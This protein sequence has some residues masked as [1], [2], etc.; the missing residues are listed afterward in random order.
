MKVWNTRVHGESPGH[1]A[2]LETTMKQISRLGVV[3]PVLVLLWVGSCSGARLDSVSE[4]LQAPYSP[5]GDALQQTDLAG[6][7]ETRYGERGVDRLIFRVDGTFKQVYQDHQVQDYVYETPW[8]E[9]W[10]ERLHDGGL[11]I[12]LQGARYY[13]AGVDT[14]ELGGMLHACADDQED[15]RGQPGCPPFAFYDPIEDDFVYMVGELV[16]SVRGDSSGKLLLH[17]MWTHAD[18]GFAMFGCER[19]QFRRLDAP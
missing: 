14:A 15:P 8:N 9:W 18:R 5:A 10:M 13:L 3:L 1:R 2:R 7:W 12:H 19:Q 17:H 16:L 11:R 4:C 6:A